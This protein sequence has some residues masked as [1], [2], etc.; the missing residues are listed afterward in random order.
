[1]E[2]LRAQTDPEMFETTTFSELLPLARDA[3]VASFMFRPFYPQDPMAS[4][5]NYYCQGC[6]EKEKNSSAKVTECE[7]EVSDIHPVHVR[8]NSDLK[9]LAVC[10][11][12]TKR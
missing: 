10:S 12:Q 2:N 3:G 8:G 7:S 9:P 6:S 5:I 1:M 4:Q 11:E